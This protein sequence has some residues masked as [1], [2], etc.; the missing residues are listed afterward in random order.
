MKGQ[1]AP[2]ACDPAAAYW[3]NL[4][5]EAICGRAAQICC[6]LSVLACRH[7]SSERHLSGKAFLKFRVCLDLR[8]K[9]RWIVD[10]VLSDGVELYVVRR[11]VDANSLDVGKLSATGCAI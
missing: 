7:K 3:E 4:T 5:H 9:V 1:A 10:E 8:G 2:L 6:K 11:E